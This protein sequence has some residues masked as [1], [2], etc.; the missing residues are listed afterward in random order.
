VE[1]RPVGHGPYHRPAV[2]PQA[3]LRTA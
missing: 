1:D 2:N 3:W